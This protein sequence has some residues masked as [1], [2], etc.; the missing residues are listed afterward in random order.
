MTRPRIKV[1]VDGDKVSI[2]GNTAD[3]HVDVEVVGQRPIIA[4]NTITEPW[5]KRWGKEITIGVI[6]GLIV[7][8]LGAVTQM[9]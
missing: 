6:T 7:L 8:A 4:N 5:W 3:V 2:R 1:I 9:G